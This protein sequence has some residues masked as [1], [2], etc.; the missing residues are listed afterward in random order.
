VSGLR[1][2]AEITGAAVVV[3]HHATKAE[4]ER[5]G[6]TLRGHSSIEGAVDLA[7][8]IREEGQEIITV[9][10]TKSRDLPVEPFKALWSYDEDSGELLSARFFG[11][12]KVTGANL[13]VQLREAI[14]KVVEEKPG[15]NQTKLQQEVLKHKRFSK[16]M[17]RSVLQELVEQEILDVEKGALSANL[18]YLRKEPNGLPS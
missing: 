17:F 6:N 1:E 5:L 15:L 16:R 11:L 9:Q 18:H 12:G 14:L 10:S 3:I 4:K 13:R 7:L 2:I 8:L